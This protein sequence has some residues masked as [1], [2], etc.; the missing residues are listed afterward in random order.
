M[1]VPPE[2]IVAIVGLFLAIPPA[3]AILWK[4]VSHKRSGATK[5]P[6]HTPSSTFTVALVRSNFGPHCIGPDPVSAMEEGHS[7]VLLTRRVSTPAYPL[8]VLPSLATNSK[9]D[10]RS[11]VSCAQEIE[12]P[13]APPCPSALTSAPGSASITQES[14]FDDVS[15][16]SRKGE[17]LP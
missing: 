11:A 9:P 3:F 12:A 6:A 7:P 5:T 16:S 17:D 2:V 10:V 13:A 15:R 8:A 14:D 1:P 4:F